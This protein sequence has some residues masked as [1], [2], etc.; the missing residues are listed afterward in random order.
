MNRFFEKT[1]SKEPIRGNYSDSPSLVGWGDSHPSQCLSRKSRQWIDTRCHVNR[2]IGIYIF[3]YLYPWPIIS[4]K[5][6]FLCRNV[7]SLGSCLWMGRKFCI[8]T[9]I[10]T[11]V[12]K[13]PP[14]HPWRRWGCFTCT[15]VT[16]PNSCL[17]DIAHVY[18][19]CI[20]G[21]INVAICSHVF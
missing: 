17:L 9:E 7:F 21:R 4:T 16:T 5:W 14:S 11:T 12:V 13:V 6:R 18:Y 3:F 8:W 1:C 20:I 19:N 2:W 15:T 10:R